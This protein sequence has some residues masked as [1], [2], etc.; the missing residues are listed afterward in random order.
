M[1]PMEAAPGAAG[2]GS[3]PLRNGGFHGDFMGFMGSFGGFMGFIMG[4]IIESN[5]I[6]WWFFMGSN[7][8]LWES[9]SGYVKIAIEND[10]RNC[11]F[12]HRTW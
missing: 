5:G 1:R 9:P 7:E 2:G 6:L 12:F 11:G 10:H 4:F 8:I 3:Y